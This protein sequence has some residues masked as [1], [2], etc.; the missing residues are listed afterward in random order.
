MHS[1]PV[2][3]HV[4]KQVGLDLCSLPEVDGYRHLIVFIF[5]ILFMLYLSSDTNT[6]SK[7]THT[8]SK[9][10]QEELKGKSNFVKLLKSIDYFT[11]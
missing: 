9:Y 6:K 5:I 2:S 10:L 8:K 3:P 11:K 7:D 1:V 4:M